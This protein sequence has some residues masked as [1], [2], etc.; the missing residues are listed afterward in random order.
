MVSSFIEL[1]QE[2]LKLKRLRNEFQNQFR[3]WVS[4]RKR[5]R[6][7]LK[8]LEQDLSSQSVQWDEGYPW[9]HMYSWFSFVVRPA[10]DEDKNACQG[11]QRNQN[12]LE[13][14][15][16]DFAAFGRDHIDSVLSSELVEGEFRILLYIL[17]GTHSPGAAANT[18]VP[19]PIL[20]DEEV[21]IH[22]TRVSTLVEQLWPSTTYQ[23][24]SA[25]IRQIL[26]E[27]RYGPN[28]EE[29]RIMIMN[30]IEAKFAEACKS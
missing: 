14:C 6:E 20:L 24:A 13:S 9:Y 26:D 23:E 7:L 11:L 4:T 12:L 22:L 25:I 3:V 30:F 17:R 21:N 10:I 28:D 2:Y 18:R 15:V 1:Q 29:I 16:A 27:L 5:I 8:E 19:L